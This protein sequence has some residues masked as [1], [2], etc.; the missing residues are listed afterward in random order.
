M[1]KER[2]EE[3]A[4]GTK[5][6]KDMFSNPDFKLETFNFDVLIEDMEYIIAQNKRYRVVLEEIL[7]TP[8]LS[9]WGYREMARK[10]LKGD[11]HD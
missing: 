3:I 2:L 7:K 10:G 5:V 6:M 9:A 11:S 8:N 4:E 1:S